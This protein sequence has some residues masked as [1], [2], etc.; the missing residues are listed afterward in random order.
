LVTFRTERSAS[1]EDKS[2]EERSNQTPQ[3]DSEIGAPMYAPMKPR[4]NRNP[5][6]APLN[7]CYAA[8]LRLEFT[9]SNK[10][11]SHK[12]RK[13]LIICGT[14]R[15]HQLVNMSRSISGSDKPSLLSR[16]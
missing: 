10:D 8:S 4:I 3:G 14:L 16:I 2:R 1:A 5:S 7:D 12:K 15:N 13:A 9:L 6:R 11:I